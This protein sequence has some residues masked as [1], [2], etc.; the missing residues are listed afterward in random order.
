VAR[1]TIPEGLTQAAG[2][3]TAPFIARS[4]WSRP[5]ARLVDPA[6]GSAGAAGPASGGCV[7]HAHTAYPDGAAA[8]AL[9][10]R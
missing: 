7:V 4:C 8:I 2:R 3:A 6:A 5:A 9:A 1:L 10:D